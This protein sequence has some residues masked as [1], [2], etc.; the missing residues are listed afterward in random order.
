ME[1]TEGIKPTFFPV[2]DA[3]HRD[4]E[5]QLGKLVCIDPAESSIFGSFDGDTARLM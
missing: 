5:E 3:N 4:L 1:S 2:N